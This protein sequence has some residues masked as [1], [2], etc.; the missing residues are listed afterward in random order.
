[1]LDRAKLKAETMIVEG[2]GHYPH[3]EMADQVAPRIIS[4][5]RGLQGNGSKSTLRSVS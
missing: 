2:A 5:V 1:M 4:F 3:T